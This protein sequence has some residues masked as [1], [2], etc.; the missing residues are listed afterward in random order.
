VFLQIFFSGAILLAIG[1][2]GEYLA[3]V[4]DESKR[5]PLYVVR[6]LVN[7]PSE[8]IH[9]DRAVILVARDAAPAFAPHPVDRRP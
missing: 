2:V 9:A 1:L 3:R 4:Y 7:V 8:D 5:R 6:E